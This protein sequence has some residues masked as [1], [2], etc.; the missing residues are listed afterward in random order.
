MLIPVALNIAISGNFIQNSR[1]FALAAIKVSS[2][3]ENN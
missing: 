3:A 1:P 2:Y